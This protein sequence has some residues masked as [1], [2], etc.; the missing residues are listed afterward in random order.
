M[1]LAINGLHYRETGSYG[2]LESGRQS[3]ISLMGSIVMDLAP[4]EYSAVLYW[5]RLPAS[6]RPWFSS[7]SFFDGFSMGRMLAAV[8]EWDIH[9]VSVYSLKQYRHAP[10]GEW[11]DVGG[12]VLQF[13]LP[14]YSL[15]ALSYNLPLSQSDNPQF[16]SW[17]EESWQRV[18]ARLIIDGVAYR[19][20]SAFVDG[21]VRGIKNARATMTLPLAAG[22]HTARLQWQNVDGSKW[23]SVSFITDAAS[24]F[25]SVFVSINSW[26]ND[27]QIKC[28]NEIAGFEDEAMMVSNVAIMDSTLMMELDYVVTVQLSVQHGWISVDSTPGII[29]ASGNGERDEFILFSG[30]LSSVNELLATLSYHAFL[31]WYGVDTLQ[32]KVTDQGTTGYTKATTNEKSTSLLVAS[33]NDLPQIVVP[34]VQAVREDDATTIFGIT[35]VDVDVTPS[36]ISSAVFEVDVHVIGGIVTLPVTDGLSFVEGSG[37]SDQF[38][39]FR[40]DLFSCNAALF[41]LHYQPDKDFNYNLHP[42]ELGI[43]I[44]DINYRDQSVTEAY[45]SVLLTVN[46]VD[47]AVTV[48]P[49]RALSS[50]VRGYAIK[51]SVGAL[52]ANSVHIRLAVMSPSGGLQLSL[53]MDAFP[54]GIVKVPI[55]NEITSEMNL[56]GLV[57]DVIK[58]IDSIEYS[59]VPAFV[60]HDVVFI[61]LSYT[62]D[63]S[64]V[65]NSSIILSLGF[66]QEVSLSISSAT[67]PRGSIDGG[68]KVHVR[69]KGFTQQSTLWCQFG[70]N[71]LVRASISSNNDL[72]CIAPKNNHDTPVHG[73]A[74]T[75]LVVT[76]GRDFCSNPVPFEYREKWNVISISP[77]FGPRHGGSTVTVIGSGFPH[78]EDI[79]CFFGN[80]SSVAIFHSPSRIS[81]ITPEA[82][83][84]LSAVLFQLSVAEDEFRNDFLFTF[85]GTNNYIYI[86][87]CCSLNLPHQTNSLM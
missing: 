76:N 34:A 32:I 1:V 21:S 10:V 74:V 54:A 64:V 35:A 52:N 43:R 19:H 36:S 25:A 68:T 26:N 65:D 60:G 7:P 72:L 59:R 46:A 78:G 85:T 18:K 33:V 70:T 47:D 12:S 49:S 31:N 81:C 20:V 4:G 9:T 38:I 22:S 30:T 73:P 5:K 45:A 40:C 2:I 58:V 77:Q 14:K 87:I 83:G 82:S 48:V 67:P 51:A 39:R 75:Y 71:P 27:P 15:V 84:N 63:F 17:T 57:D 41:E 86:Y 53:P 16:S 6:D 55:H 23:T 11:S 24:S 62:E 50:S 56:Q 13:S 69:G 66:H 8:G 42:D 61:S 3:P 79:A 37:F 28:P 29:F 44:R 80:L